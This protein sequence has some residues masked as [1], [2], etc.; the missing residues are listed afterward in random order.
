M[1]ARTALGLAGIAIL[2]LAGLA[3]F[4][5][6]AP[7]TLVNDD[8]DQARP[9]QYSSGAASAPRVDNDLAEF[10]FG[11][12]EFDWPPGGVPGFEPLPAA[13]RSLASIP[14]LP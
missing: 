8:L 6:F 1:M 9:S 13:K 14:E 4:I 2:A 3:S 12:V 5:R 7:D 10:R 11:Y